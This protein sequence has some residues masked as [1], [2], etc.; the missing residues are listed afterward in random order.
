VIEIALV[1]VGSFFI[2]LVCAALPG[3]LMNIEGIREYGW[4]R[5]WQLWREVGEKS[6]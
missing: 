3:V 2:G 5:Y 4:T 6:K 1:I